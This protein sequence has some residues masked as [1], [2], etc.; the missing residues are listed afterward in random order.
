[1]NENLLH[2]LHSTAGAALRP[3]SEPSPLLTY[4]DVPAEYEA[5]M[6]SCALLDETDRGLLRVSGA[7]AREFLHRLLANE[8]LP[9]G[10]D[11]GNRNLL[12]TAKGKVQFDFQLRACEDG[13]YLL[14]TAPGD[15]SQLAQ[16]LDM[17][18]FTEDVVI[19]DLSESYAPLLLAGPTA[20]SVLAAAIEV[21]APDEAYATSRGEYAGDELTVT[22]VV[23]FGGQA[24]RIDAGPGHATELWSALVTAGA[25]PTGRIV[26]DIVRIEALW[27]LAGVDISAEVYPQ[28]AR[29]EDAFSLSKG[30]YIGQEVVAKIDTYGGLNKRLCSLRL[31]HDDPVE[32]GTR[33]FRQDAESEEWRDLGVVTS[34]AYSFKD[35]SG[36]VLAYLK[37][38]HQE[39]GTVFRVGEGPHEAVVIE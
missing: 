8:V 18:L 7:D 21:A 5:A 9:L 11:A 16:A 30:C 22:R 10:P 17:Y 39:P 13:A 37:R 26:S 3:V 14:S 4:G 36:R 31:P 27:A 33:L 23:A 12:L 28:E 20:S 38:R 34:W 35:D 24:L 15:A 29:L 32:R 1:M 19:E 6:S 2:E 25:R